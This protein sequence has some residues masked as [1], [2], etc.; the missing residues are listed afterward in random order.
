MSRSRLWV[1]LD[2]SLSVPQ[3]F[4]EAIELMIDIC[5]EHA[6]GC[7]ARRLLDPS[8]GKIARL[9]ELL[10]AE[11]ATDQQDGR[12]AVVRRGCRPGPA[13]RGRFAIA[14]QPVESC[15]PPLHGGHIARQQH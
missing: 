15:G 5:S 10:L 14:A 3:A 9:L 4:L 2:G 13:D 7:G 6:H 11:Q 8:L 1:G 12:F